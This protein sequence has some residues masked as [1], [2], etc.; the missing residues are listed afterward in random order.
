MSQIVG[1]LRL[2][3][4]TILAPLGSR[5]LGFEMRHSG[6]RIPTTDHHAIPPASMGLSEAEPDSFSPG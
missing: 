2:N 6:F 5:E 4:M 1:T 3:D